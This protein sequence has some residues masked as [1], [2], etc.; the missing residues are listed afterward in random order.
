MKFT[1]FTFASRKE[2]LKYAVNGLVVLFNTETN[3]IIHL[4]IA[5]LVIIVSFFLKINSLEWILVLFSIGFV[6]V[7][8]TIN[9]VIEKIC[10][11]I[12]LEK[13]E[14]I[15]IIKDL[16]AAAVLISVFIATTIGVLIFFPKF[17]ALI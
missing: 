15:K 14:N 13:N 1:D 7:T 11:L 9:T 2:S 4:I 16:S 17:L 5:V 6:I 10:N 8:E 12:S 3:A